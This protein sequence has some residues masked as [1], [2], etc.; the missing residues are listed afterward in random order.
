MKDHNGRTL[1]LGFGVKVHAPGRDFGTIKAI[2]EERGL[3]LIARRFTDD[4][5]LSP[6]DVSQ[7]DAGPDERSDVSSRVI[8]VSFDFQ[9][10]ANGGDPDSTSPTLRRYHQLLWSKPLPSGA[11]FDLSVTT[12]GVY[13]H[14][15][16]SLGEFRLTS[17]AVIAT[18]RKKP[19]AKLFPESEIEAFNSIGYT[20]GGMMVFPGNKINGMITINGARGFNGSIADRFDLTLEC[21]RRHY[22]GL[23]SPLADVL[24][25]Y[26]DFF[27]LFGDFAGY[28][29]FFLLDDLVTDDFDVK[30]FLPFDD[31]RSLAVPGDVDTYQEFR[32]RSIE[33]VEARNKRIDQLGL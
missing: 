12:P 15:C 25:R 28:V 10:D 3:V 4:T 16:S 19:I 13:L 20:I 9:S 24:S 1:T 7:T 2:D 32:C 22:R 11:L 29:S 17:D 6:T 33:F 23:P 21:I 8:D 27:A 14:H 30:F 31:F 26:G 5:W 18:F